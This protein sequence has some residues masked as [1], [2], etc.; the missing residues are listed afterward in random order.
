MGLRALAKA[1][2]RMPSRPMGLRCFQS[3]ARDGHGCSPAR[4]MPGSQ[5]QGLAAN[6]ALGSYCGPALPTRSAMPSSRSQI[7]LSQLITLVLY[8][9]VY[10]LYTNLLNVLK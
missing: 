1:T 6:P 9:K 5:E 2:I 8:D 3:Q 7:C 10:H 4:P